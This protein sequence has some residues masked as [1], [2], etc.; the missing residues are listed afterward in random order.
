MGEIRILFETSDVAR[1]IGRAASTVLH[2]VRT[3]KLRPVAITPSGCRLYD[4]ADVEAFRE[5]LAAEKA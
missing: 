5:Q 3:Q 2:H 4:P 1:K